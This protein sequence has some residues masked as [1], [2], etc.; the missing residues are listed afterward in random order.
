MTEYLLFDADRKDNFD[1]ADGKGNLTQHLHYVDNGGTPDFWVALEVDSLAAAFA[2]AEKS[3][4]HLHIVDASTSVIVGEVNAKTTI[5]VAPFNSKRNVQL[6]FCETPLRAKK[7]QTEWGKDLWFPLKDSDGFD[8]VDTFN[9]IHDEH[10]WFKTIEVMASNKVALKLNS[11]V[12][13][14]RNGQS[15]DYTVTY[16]RDLSCIKMNGDVDFVF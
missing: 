13:L 4:R 1:N 10:I 5:T 16:N 15:V 7:T 11:I 8:S 12:E 2:N 9:E 6:H 14:R 3:H